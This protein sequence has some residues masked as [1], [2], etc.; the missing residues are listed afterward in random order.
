MHTESAKPITMFLRPPARQLPN[1][2]ISHYSP[3]KTMRQGENGDERQA[4]SVQV[5]G[6]LVILSEA[7]NLGHV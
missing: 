1:K 4:V 5:S 6:A 7:K 3:K 2:P